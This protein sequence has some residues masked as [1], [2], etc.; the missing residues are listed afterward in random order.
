M[1]SSLLV[2]KRKR[3]HADPGAPETLSVELSSLPET[4]AG[5]V[6]ASFPSLIP[7][8]NTAFK[9]YIHEEDEGRDFS[10]RRSTIAGETE[11]VEFSGSQG[12]SDGPSSRYFVALRQ[13]GSSKLI[14]QPAPIYSI[15]RQ[16]KVLKGFKSA[17]PSAA[18]RIHARNVL[19]ETFGTKK[20]KQAIRAHE[21][22]KVDVSAMEGVAGV[23]Q[24]RIEEG[25]EN[26]PTKEEAVDS[27]NASRLIPPYDVDAQQPEDIYPLH[28]IIPE[29][30]WAA[31]DSILHRLKSAGS[32]QARVR[33]LPNSRSDWIRQHLML[34]YSV[35]K[36]N[37]KV[38]KMLIY[39]SALIA[40]R[41]VAGRNVPDRTAV[42]EK[43]SPAPETVVDGILSRF[44]ETAR[45][46]TR[47]QMTSENDT[48][49]LTYLFA[50]CLKVDDFARTRRVNALFK[51]LGC[52]I[53]KLSQ[54]DL[55]RLGLPDIAAS[56]KRAILKAPLTFPKPR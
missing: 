7:P 16:V 32:D 51:S 50:L 49:L 4:Q 44:T 41:G 52:T 6:L 26:L 45:G 35:P 38:V 2:R 8:K 30:E 5:P 43:L 19:G 23:L 22:N 21:R 27:A 36:P 40:F 18:D 9:C 3:A 17:E 11:T 31:M 20:A 42:L 13:P 28:N 25:T 29:Q 12:G 24:D 54:Q 55:K 34:A 48:K 14:L 46:S 39:A 33:L 1:S 56:N 10:K 15:S 47:A 37:S 53:G